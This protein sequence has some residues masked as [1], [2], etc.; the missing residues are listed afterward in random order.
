MSL[1]N[2]I[3]F[4]TEQFPQVWKA[5]KDREEEIKDQP[6][7]VEPAKSGDPT[8]KI[9]KDGREYY[10]HSKYDPVKE[11]EKF[12]AQFKDVDKYKH[13]FFYG[14]GLGYHIEAFMEKYPDLEYTIY[15]PEPA[16]FKAFLSTK[17]FANPKKVK[18]IY[19]Q[20]IR[21]AMNIYL[22]DFMDFSEGEVLFITLPSYQRIMVDDYKEFSDLL[23][24]MIAGKRHNLNANFAY[25]KKWIINSISNFG[26]LLKCPNILMEKKEYFKG[27]PVLLVAAGPSLS[28]EYE[29]IR[30]IKEQGLAYVFPVGSGVNGLINNGIFPD[31]AGTFDPSHLNIKVFEDIITGKKD[32]FPLVFGSSVSPEILQQYKGPKLHM[33]VS[34][35]TVA[36]FYLKTKDD[37]SLELVHDATTVAVVIL[38]LLLRLGANPI[39][40]VGQNL[41][42]LSNRRYA[43]GIKYK[44]L[45][46]ELPL[47]ENKELEQVVNVYGEMIFT[48]RVYIRMREQMELYIKAFSSIE[49]IN[50]TKG[51][52]RIKGAPFIPLA[53]VIETRLT[54]QVVDNQ[55]YIGTDSI[56]D[57]DYI[58]SQQ[59]KLD[60]AG[61]EVRKVITHVKE[62]FE[63]I[64]KLL[65]QNN[66]EQ[67]D[68]T[69]SSFDK[70]LKKIMKNTFYQLFLKPMDRLGLEFLAKRINEIKFETDVKIKAEKVLEEFGRLF[71]QMERN[72][73]F[74]EPYLANLQGMIKG[75][76][77]DGVYNATVK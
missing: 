15:E 42:Y 16:I 5:L 33:I 61:N 58:D 75:L 40:L 39:I 17:S 68:K 48:K 41:G 44:H 72:L 74:L 8:L 30:Y 22:K 26:E 65:R 57:Y 35:D 77:G 45:S 66:L 69:I 47:E 50:T 11:A 37:S 13:I 62:Q 34:Q 32:K 64:E 73:E 76:K 6:V 54:R 29:N 23:M 12:V 56:Y 10:V 24:F 1:I 19:V 67:V 28:E 63:V 71:I 18:N 53:K 70:E 51:G 9:E 25:Q 31:A 21:R 14:A 55:W 4:L 2:N 49:V 59:H 52:A 20:F 36:P 27:R 60:N 46:S 3:D 7:F 43:T 38:E